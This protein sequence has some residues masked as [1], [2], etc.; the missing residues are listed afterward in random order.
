MRRPWLPA[1]A[2]AAAVTAIGGGFWIA[3]LAGALEEPRFTRPY[4]LASGASLD[5]Q[6]L[7]AG[8]A[9]FTLYCA[10]CHGAGGDGC[11]ASGVTIRPPPRSFRR[12]LF[13]FSGSSPGMLPTDEALDR[14]IRRGLYGTPMLAWG[15]PEADRARLE[16]YL[17]TLSP[18]WQHESP[19]RPLEI[20]GDPWKGREQEA[21]RRGEVLYHVVA[22]GHAGCS[23]CHP[24]YA[25]R[26]AIARM[27]KEV[28]GAKL[29]LREDLYRSVLKESEYPL[30]C[31][32][33]GN[34]KQMVMAVPPDFLFDRVK[35][36][37]PIGARV[38]GKPYTREGQRLDLYRTIAGGVGGTAMPQWKGAIPEENLWALVYYVQSLI[39]RRGTPGALEMAGAPEGG[40]R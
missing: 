3:W 12:G 29:E 14:T 28:P 1:L 9:S 33:A 6:V 8:Q 7:N 16:A 39:A 25:T 32:E 13:K 19:G 37:F 2:G 38:D 15:I 17:K 31:D 11:G 30:T 22:R 18:R 34:P 40:S 21:I 5:P 10:P 35:T 4:L 24:A 36:A 20:S 23:T 27:V 26:E